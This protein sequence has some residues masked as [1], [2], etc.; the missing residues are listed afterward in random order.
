MRPL[1][2]GYL[3]LVAFLALTFGLSY[4]P[5]GDGLGTATGLLVGLGKTLIIVRVFMEFGKAGRIARVWFGVGIAWVAILATILFDY[6]ARPWDA[7]PRSWIPRPEAR[8]IGS[9]PDAG[10]PSVPGGR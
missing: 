4:L 1:L 6:A 8:V 5:L 3:G 2:L 9:G 7:R 10:A